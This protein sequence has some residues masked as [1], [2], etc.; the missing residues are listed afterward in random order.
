MGL[1]RRWY[2]DKTVNWQ[3]KDDYFV[4]EN[5]ARNLKRTGHETDNALTQP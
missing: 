2:Y 3:V 5:N 4:V 1:F